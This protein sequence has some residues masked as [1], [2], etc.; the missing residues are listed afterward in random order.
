MTP[1]ELQEVR[2]SPLF[3]KLTD[4]Q[5]E[6]LEGG[7][8]VEAPAGTVLASEGE[9]TGL[10]QVI[11]EGEVRAWRTYDRQAILLGTNKA[12]AFMGETMLLLDIPWVATCRVSKAVRL[13]QLDEQSF[14]RMMTT[15]QTVARDI[16]RSS[17]NR[18]RNLEGYSQQREKLVSLGTMAAG[19]AHELN[20]PA[21]AARRAAAHMQETTDNIQ[22]FLCRLGKSLEPAHWR[23][24][25]DAAQEAAER[26]APELDHLAR[27]DGEDKIATWLNNQGVAAAW[28]LAPTF[29]NAGLDVPWLEQ[30][31]DKIPSSG[32]AD[33]FGWLEARLNLK[34]LVKEVE[35][36][37]GRI[38][39]L[40][41]AVK[42]YSYMDQ[43][44]VQEVDIHEGIESTLTMLGHKLRNVTLVR[45]FDRSIPRIAAYGSELNQVWTN[46][47]DNAIAAV[48]GN[49][50]ICV[51]TSLEDHQIVVEIVDNG[52]GI[53]PEVQARMFEP[54]FTTKSVGTGTGLGL[55]I[56]NRIV[57]DRHGG[58]IEFESKPGE[59]RFRVR[60]PLV[61]KD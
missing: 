40:V 44:P 6:C 10:F 26:K 23:H 22:S 24:L 9:K 14:W 49:G 57:G 17:S 33:A 50:K 51:G 12:G 18:M 31:A 47:L 60:L 27:S 42:S 2:S 7:I 58:E 46:L 38:A 4:G 53:P 39:E 48:N 52:P 35:Q 34:A 45:A 25:L 3:A 37:T 11:L 41:K 19:L 1:S 28:E 43:S 61:R 20:N 30:L 15:C 5:V 29:Q 32:R 8:I 36:S 59:T 21:A 16:F 13:F 56:S 54:F 55:V